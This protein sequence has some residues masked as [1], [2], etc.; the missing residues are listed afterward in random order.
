M[1][2]TIT[3]KTH[4]WAVAVERNSY[5]AFS[6]ADGTVASET[7]SYSRSIVPKHSEQDFHIFK[8]SSLTFSEIEEAPNEES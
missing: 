1:T 2:T 6:S 8:G 3:V 4:D 7:H 5:D